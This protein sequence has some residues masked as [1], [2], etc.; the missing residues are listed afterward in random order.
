[1]KSSSEDGRSKRVV[2]EITRESYSML[3][4]KNKYV[5]NSVDESW[6]PAAAIV[7]A[8]S[9]VLQKKKSV[10]ESD[11]FLKCCK[12]KMELSQASLGL[13]SK[14]ICKCRPSCLRGC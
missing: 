10:I 13:G 9:F 1:M 6:Q 8:R 4:P 14:E 7:S 11:P 12:L 3:R 2:T 5:L